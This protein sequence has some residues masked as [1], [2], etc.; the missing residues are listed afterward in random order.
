[1]K[2]PILFLVF[3]L[4]FSTGL[5]AQSTGRIGSHDAIG[6]W[7]PSGSA[8]SFTTVAE[9]RSIAQ[10][11]IDI[12]GLKANFEVREA[13]IPNAA[14]V[15]YGGKRY[16]LYNPNFIR[17][18]E[19]TTG[20]RWAGISVLAHEIGHHLNG[21]TITATGSQPALELESDEFSGFVLRKMGASLTEAQAAMKTLA[22]VRSSRTHPGQYDRLTA[23]EDGWNK[24]DGQLTGRKHTTKSRPAA[25]PAPQQNRVAVNKAPAG[26]TSIDQRSIIG[27]VRFNADAGSDYYVTSRYN[28]VK[29]KNNQ[30]SVIGKL[31]SLNSRQYPYLIYDEANTQLLVDT[32]GNIVT[33]Q[34][35]QV[36]TLSAKRG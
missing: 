21:H 18:L 31:A 5:F 32:R 13:N 27:Y 20:T 6:K 11:I 30:L 9:G 15:V 35:R 28:L 14:A 26:Q 1:M 22:S 8:S 2:N 33:R 36:G 12:V 23:I 25:A 34:G 4:L 3:S 10:E 7:S 24:A 17:Q 19:Q 16:V 29:V